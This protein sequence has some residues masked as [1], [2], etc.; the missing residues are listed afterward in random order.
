[1]LFLTF[2]MPRIKG[3]VTGTSRTRLTFH[4]SEADKL[5]RAGSFLSLLRAL[6]ALDAS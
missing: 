1:M 4:V 2:E 6:C 3:R 5:K